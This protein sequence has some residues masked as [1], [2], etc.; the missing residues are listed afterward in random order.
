M[1]AQLVQLSP[2]KS[3]KQIINFYFYEYLLQENNLKPIVF[4]SIME[5][6]SYSDLCIF[7][8]KCIITCTSCYLIDVF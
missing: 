4:F 2:L 6:K 1:G 7:I 3:M 5:V 8:C